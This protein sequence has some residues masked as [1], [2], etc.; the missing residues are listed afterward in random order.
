MCPLPAARPGAQRAARSFMCV[1]LLTT[2][3]LLQ[4]PRH[5]A[6]AYYR[7]NG[8]DLWSKSKQRSLHKVQGRKKQ[9]TS[10][11]FPWLW[12][13]DYSVTKQVEPPPD[14]RECLP[15]KGERADSCPG[16]MVCECVDIPVLDHLQHQ[17]KCMADMANGYRCV[18][19]ILSMGSHSTAC[20]E[21]FRGFLCMLVH[22]VLDVIVAEPFWRGVY[23][24]CA[25][26]AKRTACVCPTP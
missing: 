9:Y 8:G 24:R 25:D 13:P 4:Q 18:H 10:E 6:A 17:C 3:L 15:E 16:G 20:M 5:Q 1:V 2:A 19:N 14:I 23:M 26:F 21:T 11:V 22:A 12:R 7:K